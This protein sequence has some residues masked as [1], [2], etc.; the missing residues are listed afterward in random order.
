MTMRRFFVPVLALVFV[1]ST[2]LM[3]Q[4][5]PPSQ[6]GTVAQRVA[7]TNISIE[8]GRPTA[9]G[10]VLFGALV[11]WD[12]IWHPGAD[13]ATQITFSRA[14]MLDGAPVAKGTYT[15]WLIPRAT[16]AWTFILNRQKN[17]QHTPYPGTASDALRLEVAPDQATSVETLTYQFP[18][19]LR[20]EATLR[21]QWGTT[22]ISMKI[23]APY[24]PE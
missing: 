2:P 19:V 17:I 21:L 6:R 7:F 11:P 8:Y 12:S 16:G 24:R 22:G 5:Y 13:V 14:I 18:M 15:A 23:K 9:R 3:A 1:T 10:R 4:G 20:D